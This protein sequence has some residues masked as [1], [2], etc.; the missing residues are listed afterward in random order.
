M[1]KRLELNNF[2]KH[3]HLVVEFKPGLNGVF[4]ANYKGK[5]TIL[6]GIMFCLGGASAVPSKNLVTNGK[7]TGFKQSLSFSAGNDDYYVERSKTA[8]KLF[9]GSDDTGEL[10]ASGTSPVND[11]IESILG[12]ST[13][14]FKQ[15]RYGEQKKTDAI[16]TLGTAK[17]HEI[18]EQLT[19]AEDVNN[20]IKKLGDRKKQF[21]TVMSMFP[22]VDTTEKRKELESVKLE[23]GQLNNSILG[24]EQS[25]KDAATKF[26]EINAKADESNKLQRLAEVYKSDK[27]RL[28][29]EIESAKNSAAAAQMWLDAADMPEVTLAQLQEKV[30][31]LKM[32]HHNF[33]HSLKR[34]SDL[35]FKLTVAAEKLKAAAD[36]VAALVP[37]EPVTLEAMH[38]AMAKVNE[39]ASAY[40]TACVQ[41]NTL[42]KN[43]AA[44]ICGE[45]KRP[46]DDEN[47]MHRL[48]MQTG[49]KNLEDQ[50]PILAKAR[51]D[52]DT[53]YQALRAQEKKAVQY[54]SDL[55]RRTKS[56]DEAKTVM[57]T[58]EVERN[59]LGNK[60]D[61]ML[62]AEGSK[63]ALELATAELKKQT[64][65]EDSARTVRE[66][67]QRCNEEAMSL[68]A[69]L[70]ALVDP[71]FSQVNHDAIRPLLDQAAQRLSDSRV[72]TQKVRGEVNTKIEVAA[73]LTTELFHMD[74]NNEKHKEAEKSGAVT[75][76]LHKFLRDNRDR[77]MGDV[78]AQFMANAS[79]FAS[80]CTDG[81]IESVTRSDEG[82]FGYVE[83][84]YEMTVKEASG[85]QRSIMGLAVQIALSEAAD[86]PLDIIMIDEPAADM[87]PEH[88]MATA[89]M[90]ASKGKQVI[91]ISHSQMDNSVCENIISL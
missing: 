36:H 11:K 82:E 39:T 19:G 81:V 48:G 30:D 40:D 33:S 75:I 27:K 78:W 38:Q 49:L 5:S 28:A 88:S 50:K 53:A 46:F 31:E 21:E 85:A 24:L 60:Q 20:A 13:R 58:L 26:Q 22:F 68:Q 4:G 64:E 1:L 47:P 3:E 89:M 70:D 67:L 56:A 79:Q 87:D 63:V 18:I 59:S 84:G 14:M 44:G 9:K 83:A 10:L 37:A 80:A 54:S 86:C 52:A 90:L 72:C 91:M 61:I 2:K 57:L 29:I 16:L 35:D 15:L 66:N 76:G 8:A 69:K 34:I 73:R 43:L 7:N 62:Q 74:T 45:C 42:K 51:D 77:Y 17:L 12:M 6:S 65:F 25:E 55:E 41:I 23:V 71:G 32:N